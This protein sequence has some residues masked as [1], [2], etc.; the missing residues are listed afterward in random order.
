MVY[1]GAVAEIGR[2][3]VSKTQIQPERGESAGWRK[4]GQLNLSP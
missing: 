3:P 1:V 4:M 2:N